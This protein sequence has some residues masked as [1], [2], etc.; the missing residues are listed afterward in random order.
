MAAP[1]ENPGSAPDRV[2][3]WD[4]SR[5]E[6]LE[7]TWIRRRSRRKANLALLEMGGKKYVLKTVEEMPWIL[8][9]TLGRWLMAR[10]IA[11]YRKLGDL[12]GI[13][14]LIA[15]VGKD[16]FLL[17]FEE[18][19]PLRKETKPHIKDHSFEKLSALVEAIHQRG[20]V[21]LDLGQ[22]KNILVRPDGTP[23]IVDFGSAMGAGLPRPLGRVLVFLLGWIDR[24][25][26]LMQRLRYGDGLPDE[27][28]RKALRRANF[29]RKLWIFNR[30]SNP[31]RF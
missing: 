31:R 27:A 20:V 13:P 18:G 14:R 22:R 25:G 8:R 11:T 5:L 28:T 12:E 7:R 3:Q 9:V 21:H 16:A 4:P 2:P 15:R 29:W 23:V 6:S 24:R 17:S 26:L 1:A 19:L 30:P 10:E